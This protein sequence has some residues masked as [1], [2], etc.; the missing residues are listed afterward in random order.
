MGYT[1]HM[2]QLILLRHGQ[3]I[4][5]ASGKIAGL[6]DVELSDDGRAQARTAGKKLQ[7]IHIDTI[8]T[9]TLKRAVQTG[10]VIRSIMG[11]NIPLKQSAALNER[12]FGV[13]SGC[14][15]SQLKSDLG[16]D[17]YESSLSQWDT[18]PPEGETLKMVSKR[19]NTFL[20]DFVEPALLNGKS[21]LI[22]SHHHTLKTLVMLIDGIDT[23]HVGE[24]KI[25]NADPIIYNF[26]IQSKAYK[27]GTLAA[28]TK[29][30]L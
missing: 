4:W 8:C 30:L 27:L 23:Q 5:N 14:R 17:V 3:S 9:S 11:E 7:S 13:Y 10:E 22:I 25:E 18:H 20:H 12:N 15:K 16:L 24:I 21:M 19:T 2:P 1:D 26:N 29:S 28:D 6:I